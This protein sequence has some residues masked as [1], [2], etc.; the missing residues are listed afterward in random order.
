MKIS[1][2]CNLWL[3]TIA[4]EILGLTEEDIGFI[5]RRQVLQYV[6]TR[7]YHIFKFLLVIIISICC[8][9]FL[10]VIV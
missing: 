3:K 9:Q 4:E 6:F 8:Y 5:S 7:Q 10:S 1:V 2:F